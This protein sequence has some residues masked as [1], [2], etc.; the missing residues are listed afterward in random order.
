[1]KTP[2]LTT[3]E[4]AIRLRYVR[5]DGTANLK[6]FWAFLKTQPQV[7]QWKCGRHLRLH[8]DDVDALLVPANQAARDSASV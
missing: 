1:M 6:G 3:E 4:A 2:F 5:R 8:V 7:R